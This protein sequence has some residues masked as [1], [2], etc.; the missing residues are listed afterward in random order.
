MPNISKIS[1]LL[2]VC[3]LAACD[4]TNPV[5]PPPPVVAP[6]LVAL[7]DIAPDYGIHDTYVR[8]GIAFVCAWNSGVLIYDVGNGI[9]GGTPAAPAPLGSIITDPGPSKQPADHNAWWFHN[10]A[11]GEHRYLFVGQEGPGVIGSK[12]SGDIHVV[13]V[14]NLYGPQEVAFFHITGAG[15]HNFWV[16][17]TNQ[18]LYAAYYNGGVVAIDVSGVLS[19]DLS[20]RKLAQLEPGGAGNTYTWG[21]QLVGSSL[22]AIDMLT[23]LWQLQRVG[24]VFQKKSGGNNVPERYSSDLW[25]FG[26]HAYTGTWGGAAR[27]GNPG[28]VLK[29]WRLSASGAPALVDSIVTPAIATVSDV[30]VSPDGKQLIMSAEGG[31][32]GG[33]YVYGLA[34]P[35]QPVLLGFYPVARGVHTATV[36]TI[37][38]HRYVFAAKNPTGPALLIL[39]VTDL[40]Q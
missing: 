21:V 31:T 20:S 25:V 4:H 40:T 28:N 15:T 1:N 39:D 22:Y 10:A 30:E 9:A 37:N 18:I 11:T 38:G 33:V 13:D 8:N 2:C 35:E 23:G 32:N 26:N 34:D 3:L 7:V 17:E 14:S 16:D 27:N 29:I 6:A 36:A 5:V 19:G 24:N 12:A